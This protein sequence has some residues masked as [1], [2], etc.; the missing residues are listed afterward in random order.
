M[1]AGIQ[2]RRLDIVIPMAQES[3]QGLGM[4]GGMG[5]TLRPRSHGKSWRNI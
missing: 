2:Q 3:L 1:P 4:K 5:Q